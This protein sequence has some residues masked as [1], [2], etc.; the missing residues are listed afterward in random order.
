MQQNINNS[1]ITTNKLMLIVLPAL[2]LL[3]S[4]C[5]GGSDDNAVPA[6]IPAPVD[7]TINLSSFQAADV[8]I[9]QVDFTGT[10]ANQGGTVD[11]NTLSLPYSNALVHNSLLYISDFRNHRLLGFNS[12]PTVNNTPADF[13]LGQVDFTSNVTSTT[14]TTFNGTMSP[15]V[16]DGKM[17]IPD[18]LNNR[19][20]MWDT[21]PTSGN[22]PADRVIGQADF[23]TSTPSCARNGLNGPAAIWSVGTKLII[24]EANNNR[25][26]IWNTLPTSNQ[27]PADI[28]LGQQSF[29]RCASNDSDGDGIPNS[30]TASTLKYPTGVWSDGT[31]LVISDSNNNRVLIWNSFPTTNAAAADVVLGQ[32]DFSHV[33]ANDDDQNNTSGLATARSLFRPWLGVYSNGI[34]LFITDTFNNRVLV[35]NSFPS[36]SFEPADTVLGQGD[37]NQSQRNDDDQNGIEDNAATARTLNQPGGIIQHG[38]KLIVTDSYNH[39]YLIYNGQ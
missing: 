28:V 7:P 20:L 39:R 29:D 31:R 32:S 18:F 25:V 6:P 23:T 30:P 14:A 26:L 11:A 36:S 15:V 22:I 16:N 8:V 9:G 12:L 27:Q 21:V 24:T 13:V 19:V 35:W 33:S 4:A 10:I 1:S 17:F 5:G 38:D 34:Q 37:F 2:A 3:L